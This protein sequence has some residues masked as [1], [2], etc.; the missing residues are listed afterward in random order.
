MSVEP[1]RTRQRFDAGTATRIQLLDAERQSLS[2]AQ[3]LTQG[4]AA[5]TADYIAL[6]KALGLGWKSGI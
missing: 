6:Q 1:L 4:T 5:M 3:A 2:A